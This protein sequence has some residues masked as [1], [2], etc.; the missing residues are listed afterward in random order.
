MALACAQI[1]PR[2]PTYPAEEGY[3]NCALLR[4]F[5]FWQ[6]PVDDR[7]TPSLAF[8]CHEGL[9]RISCGRAFYP[10]L[11]FECLQYRPLNHPKGVLYKRIRG[12]KSCGKGHAHA[13]IIS[14]VLYFHGDV[15]TLDP[16]LKGNEHRDRA[17]YK[18]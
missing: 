4:Y 11:S 10:S 3:K 9:L 1:V 15:H 17:L 12:F 7:E 16:T 5:I 18:F 14:V 13:V 6:A 8:Y 2:K